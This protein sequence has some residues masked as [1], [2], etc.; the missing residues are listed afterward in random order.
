MTMSAEALAADYLATGTVAGTP[1]GHF[2]DGREQ[3]SLSGEK[4]DIFDPGLGR[5]FAAVAAGDRADAELA[6]A[7]SVKAFPAWR[8]L[9]P[10]ER[11]RILNRMAALIRENADQLAMLET[12]DVGKTLAESRGNAHSAARTFEYYAGVCDKLQGDSLPVGFGQIG[13]TLLE[14]VGVVAQI[15][16]WNFPMTTFARGIAPALAAGCCV[17]AKPAETTPHTAVLL[18][19]LLSD[20]GLPPGVCNVVLGEGPSVGATLSAHPDV[21][22][23]TFTG[24]T[25]TGVRVMQ[26][27]AEHFASVTMELGGKSPVIALADCDIEAAAQG[28]AGAI[29]EN[30]GQICS[31]GSRLVVD[32]AIHRKLVDRVV[33]IAGEITVGHGL[34]GNKM[35]AINSRRQLDMILGFTDR[36]RRDGRAILCG[37]KQLQDA[38]GGEGWFIGPTVIDD[39][40]DDDPCIQEEIFGPVLSVQVVDGPEDALRAA[41]ATR[42]GLMAGIY[43][44]NISSALAIARDLESG[45]V[46][47]N[48]YWG[49]GVEVPFGGV[50]HSGFGREKGL[51]AVQAYCRVK[52]VVAQVPATLSQ[53]TR[54]N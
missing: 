39:L 53:E 43:T 19:R 11:G 15:I 27:A 41:N 8:R 25:N 31:A 26:A 17:V 51:V 48:D 45:S 30:A 36:A 46:T 29:F 34:R 44:S 2:I 33:E 14:P 42:Y 54:N 3:D 47:I 35:G 6:V 37:G 10:A 7:S 5:P 22:H 20:A 4:M 24:S 32:R 16:P 38:D 21:A 49:G 40:P 52:S 9:A 50:G 13:L 18:A 1:S 12:L 28:A 23:V